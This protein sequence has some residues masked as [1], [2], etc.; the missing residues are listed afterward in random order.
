MYEAVKH[1]HI[2]CATLSGTGLFLR[3]ILMMSGSPLLQRRWVKTIPHVNDTILLVAALALTVL[4]GQYPFVNGWLTAKVLGVIVYIVLG[5]V[6]LK[7][8]RPRAVRIAA[9]F[10][11]LGVFGYIVSVALTKTPWGFLTGLTGG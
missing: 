5:A 11:A 4:I 3:G 2:L 10:A 8:G 6:A 9:L 7:P 1:L